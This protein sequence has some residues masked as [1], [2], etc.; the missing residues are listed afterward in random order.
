[1][2]R[3]NAQKDISRCYESEG[4]NQKE[5]QEAKQYY[6]GAKFSQHNKVIKKE[7]PPLLKQKN[8]ILGRQKPFRNYL[9]I[10]FEWAVS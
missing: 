2:F 1:M 7:C 10:Q 5:N 9:I 4:Y 8:R 3:I 6:F